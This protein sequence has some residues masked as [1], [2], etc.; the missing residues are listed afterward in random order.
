MFHLTG[1]LK[2]VGIGGSIA[3]AVAKFAWTYLGGLKAVEYGWI[4]IASL[5]KKA[6]IS[7][8]AAGLVGLIT[9]AVLAIGMFA[10]KKKLKL[11][12]SG[13]IAW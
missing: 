6:A 1:F 12:K 13:F 9:T 5:L 2:S 10:F 7:A 11:G 8:G 4:T 3:A